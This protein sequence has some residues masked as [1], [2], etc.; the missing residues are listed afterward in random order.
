MHID[1]EGAAVE[2]ELMWELWCPEPFKSS[3][4]YIEDIFCSMCN[5][6]IIYCSGR[7][8]VEG[9]RNFEERRLWALTHT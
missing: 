9:S 3:Q 6:M 1:A 5:A 4:D 2:G 8:K 7:R